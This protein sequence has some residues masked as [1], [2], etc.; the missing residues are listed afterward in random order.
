MVKKQFEENAV[1]SG[2][3]EKLTMRSEDEIVVTSVVSPF[4]KKELE[5]MLISVPK[6][7]FE[8]LYDDGKE[9]LD[10]LVSKIQRMIAEKD[11]E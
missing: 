6:A 9:F 5:V 10:N 8:V 7:L 4:T 2:P 11:D 1:E 3:I